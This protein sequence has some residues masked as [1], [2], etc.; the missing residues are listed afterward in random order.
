MF[1]ARPGVGDRD[2]DELST[3]AGTA[4]VWFSPD[5]ARW[6]LEGRPDTIPLADGGALASVPYGSERWLATELC[7]YLGDAV[8]LEPEG[9][10]A[11]VAAR[12]REL[13]SGL[14]EQTGSPHATR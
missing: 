4:S 9:M 6:E 11:D 2:D 10:R 12:A 3:T 8:L 7:R 14:R 5:V 1:E 13:G